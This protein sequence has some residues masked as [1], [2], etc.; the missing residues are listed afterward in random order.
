MKALSSEG[1]GYTVEFE[2][3]GSERLWF[4]EA[5][6]SRAEGLDRYKAGNPISFTNTVDG[7][8]ISRST[9]KIATCHAK[10]RRRSYFSVAAVCRAVRRGLPRVAAN[11]ARFR[12]L[13]FGGRMLQLGWSET[14]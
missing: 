4:A 10:P 1:A 9:L 6:F 14:Y 13:V 12:D 5:H 11:N 8:R 2:V 3:P 7:V